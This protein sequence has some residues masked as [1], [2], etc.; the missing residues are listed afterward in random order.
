MLNWLD[1]IHLRE[2]Q[3]EIYD[4]LYIWKEDRCIKEVSFYLS[5]LETVQIKPKAGRGG[6]GEMERR[7]YRGNT[8][9]KCWHFENMNKINKL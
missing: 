9:I 8:E 6:G 3:R 4:T 7:S 1:M 5:D 2:V